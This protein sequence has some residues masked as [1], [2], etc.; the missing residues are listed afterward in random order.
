MSSGEVRA[1]AAVRCRQLGCRR[2]GSDQ[3]CCFSGGSALQAVQG[4][5]GQGTLLLP[6]RRPPSRPRPMLAWQY[7]V[8]AAPLTSRGA[9]RRESSSG[10]FIGPPW[11]ADSA[12]QCTLRM[13]VR[14]MVKGP[15]NSSSYLSG[16]CY[17]R[18]WAG[19]EYA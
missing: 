9:S 19:K 17:A 18:I 7:G 8:T 3:T 16:R 13:L 11:S 10:A 2:D 4:T 15:S 6:P 1:A 12:Q 14:S 5:C